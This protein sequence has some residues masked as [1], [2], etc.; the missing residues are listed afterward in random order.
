MTQQAPAPTSQATELQNLREE[1]EAQ[2]AITEKAKRATEPA[3]S[4]I[5]LLRSKL[6]QSLDREVDIQAKGRKVVKTI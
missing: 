4:E 2:A 5:D 6:Y 3:E 1:I